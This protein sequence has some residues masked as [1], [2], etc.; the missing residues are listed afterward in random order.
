MKHDRLVF[1]LYVALIV[2][3][4]GLVGFALFNVHLYVFALTY[5]AAFSF[6]YLP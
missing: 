3:V 2:L 1:W 4:V 6:G 5:K